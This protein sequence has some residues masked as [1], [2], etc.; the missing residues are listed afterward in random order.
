MRR[1][2]KAEAEIGLA[3]A[4]L[5]AVEKLVGRA[6]IGIGL[7]AAIGRPDESLGFLVS[8]RN[9][10]IALVRR[11]LHQLVGNLAVTVSQRLFPSAVSSSAR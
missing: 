10:F 3:A 7:R 4:G 1:E 6:P 9:G 2:R 8:N 5:A 11:G